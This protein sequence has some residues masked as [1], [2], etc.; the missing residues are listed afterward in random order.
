MPAPWQHGYHL[1]TLSPPTTPM[2]ASWQDVHTKPRSKPD[3]G[4]L[5]SCTLT[6]GPKENRFFSAA[7]SNDLSKYTHSLQLSDQAWPRYVTDAPLPISASS[8]GAK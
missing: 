8:R 1:N 3:F 2:T 6:V 5:F 7:T 4:S